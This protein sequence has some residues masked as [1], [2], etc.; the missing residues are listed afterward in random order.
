M[1]TSLRTP[2]V[3]ALAEVRA[4]P[5]LLP[6][7]EVVGDAYRGDRQHARDARRRRPSRRAAGEGRGGCALAGR[8][9]A[10]CRGA[11]ARGGGSRGGRARW[12]GARGRAARGGRPA[13]ALTASAVIADSQPKPAASGKTASRARWVSRRWPESGSWA[14]VA[15]REPDQPPRRLLRD[16]EAAALLARERGDRQVGVAVEERR[17][18]AAE[19]GV[20]EQQVALVRHSFAERQRLPL[21]AMRQPEHERARLLGDRA[22]RIARAVVGDDHLRLREPAPELLDRRPD[23]RRLVAGGDQDRQGFSHSGPAAARSA[24]GSGRRCRGRR[25]SRRRRDRRA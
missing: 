13:C 14:L 1:A 10:R 25:S 12:R 3:G 6:A 9:R 7:P 20:A 15:G 17:Q 18:V 2:V 5:A 11:G 8:R 19:V 21:A 23:P 16:P 24:A 22:G 4:E